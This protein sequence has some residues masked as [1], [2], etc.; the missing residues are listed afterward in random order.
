MTNHPS[1]NPPQLRK[2][3]RL[4]HAVVTTAVPVIA[5]IVNVPAAVA[6]LE[7]TTVTVIA[8]LTNVLTVAVVLEIETAPVITDLAVV[9]AVVLETVIQVQVPVIVLVITGIAAGQNVIVV[10]VVVVVAATTL[11]TDT[12]LTTHMF[13]PATF[14]LCPV[15]SRPF[16]PKC[17]PCT[18]S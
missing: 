9:P 2:L 3:Y 17:H 12:V 16:L 1:T 7:T 15:Q 5:G 14:V 18:I 10:V 6:V 8:A 11:T 4:Q 13:Y